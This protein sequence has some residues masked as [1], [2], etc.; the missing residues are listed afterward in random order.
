MAVT[1][2]YND[3]TRRWGHARG[4]QMGDAIEVAD[5]STADIDRS[6]LYRVIATSPSTV[7]FGKG[8]S[9]ATGGEPWPQ[10]HVEQVYLLKGQMV[11]VDAV[12]SE[13]P[14]EPEE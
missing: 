3:I 12:E 13:T 8:L 9:D 14:E 10:D 6:G 7:R 4:A 11:A 5:G 1:L 2:T